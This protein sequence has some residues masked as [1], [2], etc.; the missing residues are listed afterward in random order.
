MSPDGSRRFTDKEVAMVIR[1]AS[2]IDERAGSDGGGGLSIDDLKEIAREVGISPESIS[3]AVA[4]LDEPRKRVAPSWWG[5]PN[6]HKAIH[7]VRGELNQEALGRLIRLV[8]EKTD[9]AGAISEAL[10]SVR[11]TTGDRFH[12]TQVSLTPENGETVIQVVEKVRPR[13]R[14]VAQLIPGA[15]GLVVATAL[16]PATDITALGT[17][18]LLGGGFLAGSAIGRF[19]WNRMSARSRQRV[20][21]LAAD[22]SREAYDSSKKGLVT[23]PADP[24]E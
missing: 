14:R 5:A 12:S 7:A 22:L 17:A 6:A 24:E 19:V 9:S 2:E 1:K 21:Q 3:K 18:A 13:L 23:T 20:E 15:W 4:K 11:W 10:G 16:F 8:D